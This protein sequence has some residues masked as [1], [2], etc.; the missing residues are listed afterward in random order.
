ME[1]IDEEVEGDVDSAVIAFARIVAACLEL[2]WQILP[3]AAQRAVKASPQIEDK[4]D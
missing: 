1:A 4:S 2:E 3:R